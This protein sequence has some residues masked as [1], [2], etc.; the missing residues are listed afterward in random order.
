LICVIVRVEACALRVLVAPCVVAAATV[1][2]GDVFVGAAGPR[3]GVL[4]ARAPE[5]ITAAG[6]AD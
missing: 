3:A 6:R 5:E 2:A 1:S 4:A